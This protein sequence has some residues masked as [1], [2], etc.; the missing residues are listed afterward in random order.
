MNSVSIVG[1][2]SSVSVVLPWNQSGPGGLLKYIRVFSSRPT[3]PN[4]I[5]IK[6]TSSLMAEHTCRATAVEQIVRSLR[7]RAATRQ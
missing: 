3:H 1:Y 5:G 4:W 6:L 2:F 7:L